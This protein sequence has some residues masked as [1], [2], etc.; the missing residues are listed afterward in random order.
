MK[1]IFFN[2]NKSIGAGT[3]QNF[4]ICI[5]NKRLKRSMFTKGNNSIVLKKSGELMLNT[6]N[7]KSDNI[8]KSPI[9]SP[10]LR[11]NALIDPPIINTKQLNFLA[12]YNKIN[13]NKLF[14][15]ELLD[16]KNYLSNL[17]A[18][19]KYLISRCENLKI[20]GKINNKFM[21]N[22][23]STVASIQRGLKQ[24]TVVTNELGRTKETVTFSYYVLTTSSKRVNHGGN[25]LSPIFLARDVNKSKNFY[26]LP[27]L[28][29]DTIPIEDY[30]EMFLI[31]DKSG[32]ID[33]YEFQ[34]LL[35]DKLIELENN[36]DVIIYELHLKNDFFE[37]NITDI[38]FS[39][40]LRIRDPK[41]RTTL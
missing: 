3:I 33:N 18:R 24:H 20:E 21:L 23:M 36:K 16:C 15:R 19:G 29:I 26:V 12:Q 34:Q 39:N 27:L 9:N 14:Y 41:N 22:Y 28:C 13:T 35:V 8:L 38:N 1:S 37:K 31:K 25:V 32:F 40:F 11:L 4:N 7:I 17:E 30:N 6:T 2:V 5:I 10:R